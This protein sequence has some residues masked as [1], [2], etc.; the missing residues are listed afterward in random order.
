M[1]TRICLGIL[2]IAIVFSAGCRTG[3]YKVDLDIYKQMPGVLVAEPSLPDY[4]AKNEDGSIKVSFEKGEMF[5][6]LR[7]GSS[8]DEDT[9]KK[10]VSKALELFHQQYMDNPDNRRGNGTFFRQKVVVRGYVEDI[11]LYIVEWDMSLEHPNM[12]KDRSANYI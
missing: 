6:W 7:T 11:E 8:M 1:N 3:E 10:V 12:V 4:L 5:L 9:R 2:A